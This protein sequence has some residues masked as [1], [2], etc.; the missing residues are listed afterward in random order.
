M[1]NKKTWYAH[2]HQD[3]KDRGYP[4]D[5]TETEKTYKWT[6]DYWLTNSYEGR[7]HDFKWFIQKFPNMPTW[8][9]NW[10]YLYAEYLRLNS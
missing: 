3:S 9:E 4:E 8:P 6:A 1:V 5:K 7:I 10:E 2:L